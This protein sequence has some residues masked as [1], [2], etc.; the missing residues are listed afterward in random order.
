MPV[1]TANADER[2]AMCLRGVGVVKPVIKFAADAGFTLM[3][4][5]TVPLQLPWQ[6]E[7]VCHA[8]KPV[9]EKTFGAQVKEPRSQKR[10]LGH[11]S[12][13]RSQRFH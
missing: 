9:A 4:A 13:L 10:D 6:Q 1:E 12:Q 2:E 7:P 11:L 5:V 8:A 3:H